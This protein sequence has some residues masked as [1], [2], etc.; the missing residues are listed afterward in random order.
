LKRIGAMLSAV[1]Q[2]VL[3]PAQYRVRLSRRRSLWIH[4]VFVTTVGEHPH[5]RLDFDLVPND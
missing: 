2:K 4:W 3:P 1:A 5:W